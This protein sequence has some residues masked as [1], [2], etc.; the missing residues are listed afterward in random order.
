MDEWDYYD[1]EHDE[2]DGGGPSSRRRVVLAVVVIVAAV[3]VAV[4]GLNMRSSSGG[5]A[6]DSSPS[7]SSLSFGTAVTNSATVSTV[8]A[9]AAASTTTAS[10]G[11]TATTGLVAGPNAPSTSAAATTPAAATAAGGLGDAA[12]T[13]SP[14]A[15]SPT[16]SSLPEG[17]PAPILAVFGSD[18]VTLKGAVPTAAAKGSLQ[19]LAIAS[20]RSPVPV[21]NLLTIDPTVPVGIGV[22]FADLTSAQFEPDGAVLSGPHALELDR[23]VALMNA[24]AGVTALVIGHADQIGSDPHS[25][26]LSAARAAAVVNHLVAKGISPSRLSSRALND[27]DLLTLNDD[28]ASLAL[29]RRTEFVLY[30]LLAG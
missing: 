12:A 28:A 3:A 19:A 13:T 22:R 25:L 6:S 21:N 18:S 8:I 4:V 15:L 24:L 5:T 9:A 11:S 7:A 27:N 2:D 30:G 23:V 10:V 29:N 16:Y 26:S 20:S 1:D 17:S 14:G